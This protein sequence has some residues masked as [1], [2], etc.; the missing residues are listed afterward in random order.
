MGV[1]YDGAP[2]IMEQKSILESLSMN[3]ITSS[4]DIIMKNDT[5][6]KSAYVNNS[7]LDDLISETKN[8]QIIK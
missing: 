5:K 7:D 4:I 2:R 8:G 3:I 1:C 6:I